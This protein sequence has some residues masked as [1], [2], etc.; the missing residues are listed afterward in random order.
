MSRAAD[1]EIE[2]PRR[3]PLAFDRR[4]YDS[5]RRLTITDCVI[6]AAQVNPYLGSE[7]PDAA[8]FGLDPDRLY[9][10]YRDPAALKAAMPG[11]NGKPL[12]IEH[13]SVTAADP[14]QHLIVGTVSDCRWENGKIVA[15]VSVWDA[16]AIRGIE[17]N[18]Q[19]ELSA[20]YRYVA[21]MSPGETPNGEKFDGRMVSLEFQHVALVPQGRVYGAQVGDRAPACRDMASV[22]PG[23]N[24]LR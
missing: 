15:T 8:S 23:L 4:S 11:L 9:M 3:E 16:D 10:M 12:L 17:T 7:I 22:I 6:S 2:I 18:M 21:K 19:R 24:R 5:D 1:I 14:K 20:G 13:A